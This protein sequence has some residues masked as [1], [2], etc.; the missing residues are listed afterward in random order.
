MTTRKAPRTPFLLGEKKDFRM[1][2]ADLQEA[3]KMARAT[4]KSRSHFWFF[5]GEQKEQNVPGE[6]GH[7][8]KDFRLFATIASHGRRAP[9]G[10][11]SG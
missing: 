4:R 3:Q 2:S 6:Q 8:K 9:S 11:R 7:S 5:L 10:R 1:S